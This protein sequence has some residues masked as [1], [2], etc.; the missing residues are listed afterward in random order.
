MAG[1]TITSQF[2]VT[3]VKDGDPGTPGKDGNGIVST[4]R[5]YAISANSTS[6]NDTV[7][8]SDISSWAAVSPAVTEAKPYLWAREVVTYTKSDPTVKYYC[9][10]ARGTNGVD[11]QDIEWVY[12]L[13]TDN[14]APVIVAESGNDYLSDDYLPLAKVTSGRIKGGSEGNA[15]TNVRCTDDPQGV[16]STW[17]YEWEIK[18]EKGP[19][20]NGH[21][22]WVAY[23]G[24]LT[25]HN[26]FVTSPYFADIDNEMVSVACSYEGK[27]TA[28]FDKTIGVKMWHGSAE[29]TLTK[30][31]ATFGGTSASATGSTNS[32]SATS[33]N[34]KITVNKS[35]KTIRIEISNAKEIAQ[36]TDIT[37]TIACENSGDQ[38]LHLYVNG[39]RPGNPGEKAVIYDLVPSASS[40][41]RNKNNTLTPSSLTCDVQ[42]NAGS[43]SSRA[44]STDGTLYYRKNGDIASTSDGTS[45]AINSGSISIEASDTY[46]TFAFFD[47]SGTLRDKERVIVVYDGTDG[48]NAPYDV[49]TYA[50]SK[51]RSSYSGSNIDTSVGTNGW[52]ST[53]P[54]TTSTYPYIW[55]KIEH[56]TWSGGTAT[57]SSTSYVCLTGEKG[58]DGKSLYGLSSSASLI[59]LSKN[60][61]GVISASLSSYTISLQYDGNSITSIPSGY[62]LWQRKDGGSWTSATLGS[63][64]TLA[65]DNFNDGAVGVIEYAF[66]VGT[67][68]VAGNVL[69]SASVSV[70]WEIQRMLI[71]QGK[72]DEATNY[73]FARTDTTTPLVFL[74]GNNG[75]TYWYLIADNNNAG[76]SSSPSWVAP[77]TNGS[78]WAQ[79]TNYEVILTKMIFAEMARLGSYVVYDRFFFSQYGTLIYKGASGNTL[80]TTVKASNVSSNFNGITPIVLNGNETND[81]IVCKVAFYATA[82]AQIKIT[83]TPSSELNYDFGAIGV[84]GTESS[85]GYSKWLE[86]AN[87]STIKNTSVGTYMLKKAS[88]TT[89][90][91]TTITI[92]SAGEYYIEIAYA[93]DVDVDNDDTATFVFERKSGTVTWRSVTKVAGSQWMT[94]DGKAG[95]LVPYAWFDPSDPMAENVPATGYKF[96][97]A[98]CI[99]ALAGEEWMAGGNVHVSQAGDITMQNAV[100]EGSLM[101]HKT[102]VDKAGNSITPF[103]MWSVTGSAVDVDGSTT[104][105]KVTMQYDTIIIGGNT[106]S[107]SYNLFTNIVATGYTVLLP[108]AKFFPGMRLKIINGTFTGG[109]GNA[110]TL[111]PSP[112]NL[113]VIYR[114]DTEE[115]VDYIDSSYDA[116]M[117]A[118]ALPVTFNNSIGND[119]T[120][121]GAPDSTKHIDYTPTTANRFTVF[122]LK[123]SS[124]KK[125]KS[126]ELAALENPY[127]SGTHYC[128]MIIDV[129]E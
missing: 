55:E 13:T 106:R 51:S 25:L 121:V 35:S 52:A 46:V 72:W 114:S 88:G 90:V 38:T 63:K 41:K 57:L 64:T 77:G 118:A 34:I 39:V 92:P 129:Q 109:N 53:A 9:I 7:A 87:E 98:K 68:Y 44:A 86:S 24:T 117:I 113:A 103:T 80:E 95:N 1:K 22:A 32:A 33:G 107:N 50:R 20:T 79:A 37:I 101:Y 81:I 73:Q 4:V 112:I 28:A 128:W 82:N 56:Y 108:P 100:I 75:G 18:R 110:A 67:S 124:N 61:A 31:V 60:Y 115:L 91:D 47:A 12:V 94:F 104:V 17:K 6:A 120:F 16:D 125:Y 2:S 89:P 93:C 8:P 49:I 45:L 126:I 96:R 116:N 84:L 54:S 105:K 19:A 74:D 122:G 10:G 36:V 11:A 29:Q 119:F 26:Q 127:V 40:V 23:S 27:T 99:N 59:T 71:P 42:K 69:S 111:S 66:C 48:I 65:S 85:P 102:Y 3:S 70:R 123:G 5:T 15:N 78:I 58:P 21:R 83:L 76:T 97:P 62:S 14:V 30:L 43:A